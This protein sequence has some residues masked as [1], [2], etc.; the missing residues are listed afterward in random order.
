MRHGT[1]AT[2]HSS[3]VIVMSLAAWLRHESPSP[4]RSS[5]YLTR[6]PNGC[7]RARM[8]GRGAGAWIL[9]A[10]VFGS[11]GL[12]AEPD[13][14]RIA[15]V[16][17]AALPPLSRTFDKFPSEA[18]GCW[19]LARHYDAGVG[20]VK[21]PYL[22]AYWARI[23]AQRGAELAAS[24][25]AA[26]ASRGDVFAQL[27]YSVLLSE[28]VGAPRDTEAANQ[29][30]KRAMTSLEAS[31]KQS[32]DARAIMGLAI[33]YGK[34]L[35]VAVDSDKERGLLHLAA[36][37]YY[38]P[39]LGAWGLALLNDN[40]G[41]SD[42]ST[43]V[44]ALES[45]AGLGNLE[46]ARDLGQAYLDGKGVAKDHT[47]AL[48]WFKLA[49]NNG[50]RDSQFQTALMLERGEGAPRDTAAAVDMYR[51]AAAQGSAPAA[52]N[53]GVLVQWGDGT[54]SNPQEAVEWF[55][56]AS[57][58]G[59]SFG[60]YNLGR[61]HRDGIGVPVN[62]TEA[63]RAFQSAAKAGHDK[64]GAAAAQVDATVACLKSKQLTVL[65]QRALRCALRDNFRRSII[66][67]GA[68]VTREDANYWYDVYDSSALLEGSTELSVGYTQSG[69]FARAVYLFPSRMAADQVQQVAEM[70]WIKY[71]KPQRSK[72]S[73][74]V[75]P[76]S[77]EWTLPDGIL[78]RVSRGWPETST[79]L[80][81]I[82]PKRL[83]QLEREVAEVDARRKVQK[84][85]AQDNAL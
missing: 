60:T 31:A 62:L 73:L 72:G 40:V 83:K 6:V 39:A 26:S 68:R 74:S 55:K 46:S 29:W 9:T 14:K 33:A 59:N 23:A 13:A 3:M 5:S 18:N 16:G 32:E 37:K 54:A 50:D 10:V 70:V 4:T 11:G 71:G 41:T 17:S 82:Y 69:D 12:R 27:Q 24:W 81:Y 44:V 80:E 1:R 65:F 30:A 20:T 76:V 22:A 79:S 36:S 7:S 61:A 53:L 84:A 48:K 35:G 57:E 45:A 63:K 43:A 42:P 8:K 38:P 85:L 66:E 19:E 47:S 58:W 51:R 64:A 49:A 77:F 78:I 28:G 75:G 15:A 52:N 34:G 2:F 25:L 67:A 56:K 21:D